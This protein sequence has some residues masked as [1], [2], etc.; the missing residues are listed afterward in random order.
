MDLVFLFLFLNKLIVYIK[1][2][3]WIHANSTF[4]LESETIKGK[5]EKI[6]I[7]LKQLN[8]FTRLPIEGEIMLIFQVINLLL[9]LIN[10]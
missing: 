2:K 5:H 3:F 6:I 8:M 4:C 7:F 1:V 10:T 9:I